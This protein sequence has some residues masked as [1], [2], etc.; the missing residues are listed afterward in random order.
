MPIRGISWV[1][2][3]CTA[4]RCPGKGKCGHLCPGALEKPLGESPTVSSR[5]QWSSQAWEPQSPHPP[6]PPARLAVM[7]C[8]PSS[9]P[10][11]QGCVGAALVSF[12]S[13]QGGRGSEKG[14]A[15]HGK[16]QFV[17]WTRTFTGG[18]RKE[19][20]TAYEQNIALIIL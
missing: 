17:C 3:L 7:K 14:Q 1:S 2:Y 19:G 4:Q 11:S 9:G 12:P 10:S 16:F 8:R 13:E 15:C 20:R 5:G 18:R 6:S